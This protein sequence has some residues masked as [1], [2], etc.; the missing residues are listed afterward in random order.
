MSLVAASFIARAICEDAALSA[1]QG[2]TG[3]NPNQR[4]GKWLA[5][6]FSQHADTIWRA[7]RLFEV[8]GHRRKG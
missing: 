6:N 3:E 2:L 7:R 8:F 1:A 5:E 4:F